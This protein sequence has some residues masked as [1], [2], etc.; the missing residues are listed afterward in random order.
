MEVRGKSEGSGGQGSGSHLLF[1]FITYFRWEVPEAG[2]HV[3][4]SGPSPAHPPEAARGLPY[5]R[6]PAVTH[7]SEAFLSARDW[8]AEI[9]VTLLT[10]C[11]GCDCSAY[12]QSASPDPEGRAVTSPSW[13]NSK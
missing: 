8:G 3:W 6:L 11:R 7:G 13:V 1:L 12:A 2:G 5:S 9:T 10:S 4:V